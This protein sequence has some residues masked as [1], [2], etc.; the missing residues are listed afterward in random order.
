MLVAD[1]FLGTLGDDAVASRVE[2]ADGLT[3]TVDDVERRRSRFR[4]TADNGQEI[5]VVV[6]RELQDGDVLD[7]DGTPVVVSLAA[8]EAMVLDY[9]GVTAPDTALLG[10]ALELGHAVGN[11]HW[12]LVVEAECAYLPLTD[13]R[14]RM[15]ATVE[16]HLPAAATVRYESV[17]PTLFD[18]TGGH[19]HTHAPDLRAANEGDRP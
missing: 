4:T 18:D 6:A 15:Q 19:E 17:Q 10:S 1:E 2:Q 12:D 16:D 3:V 14:E 11:R 5:G 7:A 13:S 9:S 8:V